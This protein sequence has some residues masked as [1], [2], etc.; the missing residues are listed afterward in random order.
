MDPQTRTVS[1]TAD[2]DYAGTDVLEVMAEAVRYNR[3]LTDSVRRYATPGARVMDFGAGIGTFAASLKEFGIAP[4][5]V[6]VD[7]AQRARIAEKGLPVHAST[8]EMADGSVDYIYT[9]NVL[10]HIDD[11]LSALRDLERV[12]APGG[13]IFIF[14][15]AFQILYSAF[16]R[17][18]G[19]VRR[20][21]RPGLVRLAEQAG[22]V[23][24]SARYCDSLGFA[25][26]LAFKMISDDSGSVSGTSVRIYDSL[27]FPISRML[28]TVAGPFVGKNVALLARKAG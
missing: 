9:L 14:V 5:C 19:H 18:I 25:A 22:L 6:E 13:R 11:D 24:E 2:G 26:A 12:L 8:A 15:P 4:I 10:E 28:D 1:N 7:S 20:Y 17:R 3:F 21:T 27:I 16:D 23:V